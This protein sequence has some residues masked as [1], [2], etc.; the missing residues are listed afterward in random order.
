[1]N[2]IFRALLLALLA[3]VLVAPQSATAA[4]PEWAYE[5]EVLK[6]TNLERTNRSI[7]AVDLNKCVDHYAELQAAR[8]ASRHRIYHQSMST[9]MSG[10]KLR[11]VGENVA[12][13]YTTG[14]RVVQSGWMKSSG[15]KANILNKG[16]RLMGVG[17]VR[18]SRGVWYVAQVF[19]TYR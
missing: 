3:T 16:F 19:G 4:T 10:C 1:M 6:Y 18:D 12:S 11:M 8:M 2:G 13:G 7:R 5:T 17:A 9:V 14:R 15:H